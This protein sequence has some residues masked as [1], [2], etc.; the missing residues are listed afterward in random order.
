[1]PASESVLRRMLRG[2]HVP[3]PAAGEESVPP[4]TQQG[5]AGAFARVCALAL[6]EAAGLVAPVTPSPA[7]TVAPHEIAAALAR[8]EGPMPLVLP[9]AIGDAGADGAGPARGLLMLTPALLNA[10]IEGQMIGDRAP[11]P[12]P[13]RAPTAVDRAMSAGFVAGLL[14]RLGECGLWQGQA[15]LPGPPLPHPGEVVLCLP[16]APLQLVT[17]VFWPDADAGGPGPAEI[18]H[19]GALAL[20]IALPTSAAAPE[21]ASAPP[22]PAAAPASAPLMLPEPRLDI[23]SALEAAEFPVAAVLARQRMQ[24]SEIAGWRPGDVIVLPG[25]A[26]DRLELHAAATAARPG[27]VL[28]LARLGRV[29]TRKALRLAGRRESAGFE[30]EPSPGKGGTQG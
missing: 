15:P 9:L 11:R 20:A 18:P 8:P 22:Q 17:A 6:H 16:P 24:V 21:Y 13:L 26:I 30:P 7:R 27:G 4:A 1:M 28:G 3:Q 19:S 25:A 29:G 5:A 14:A 10:L 12:A 23:A 2:A